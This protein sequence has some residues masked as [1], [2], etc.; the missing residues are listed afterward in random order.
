MCLSVS[1]AIVRRAWRQ[2][3][4]VPYFLSMIVF[5]STAHSSQTGAVSWPSLASASLL[6]AAPGLSPPSP[7]R[8]AASRVSPVCRDACGPVPL[9]VRVAR[10][11]GGWGAQVALVGACLDNMSVRCLPPLLQARLARLRAA[12]LGRAAP[13]AGAVTTLDGFTYEREAITE[14]LRTKDTSPKTGATLESTTLYP[15]LSLRSMIRAFNE[16]RAPASMA[17]P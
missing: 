1:T 7:P 2:R 14:W 12:R 13:K 6:A 4:F 15:N 9:P 5:H 8:V 11:S 10:P 3:I 16:A 17:S